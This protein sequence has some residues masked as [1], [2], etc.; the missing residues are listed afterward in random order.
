MKIHHFSHTAVFERFL[1][2][3]FH[4]LRRMAIEHLIVDVRGNGGGHSGAAT[5]LM[6]YL[7]PRPF[8]TYSMIATQVSPQIK[9]YYHCEQV[10][11]ASCSP[12][13][14]QA[15]LYQ[16]MHTEPTFQA[17]RLDRFQGR[18]VLLTD[19]LTFSSAADFA[20]MFQ[21]FKVGPVV[22]ATTGGLATGYG[23]IYT[24]TL[25]HTGLQVGVSHKYFVRANG[26]RRL[27]P[28]TPNHEVVR[29][30]DDSHDEPLVFAQSWLQGE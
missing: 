3:T 24:F 4:Q 18:V 29:R 6:A 27:R 5:A 9:A 22:G 13:L 7:S 15:P 25:P 8:R 28:V 2:R 20:A 16:Q 19:G 10:M 21:D 11:T 12:E 23:D 14:R 17:P 1:A 30:G 26:D